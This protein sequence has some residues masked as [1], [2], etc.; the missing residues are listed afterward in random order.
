MITYESIELSEKVIA[1]TRIILQAYAHMDNITKLQVQKNKIK[2]EDSTNTLI[3]VIVPIIIF[4]PIWII[5]S[6]ILCM[7]FSDGV[8]GILG[9]IVSL[10]FCIGIGFLCSGGN[11][12]QAKMQKV[13]EQI[14]QET[15]KIN[16]LIKSNEKI[17]KFIP[18]EYWY[19][20]AMEYLV[21]VVT[22]GRVNTLNEA[23]S[24]YDEQLHRWKMENI[25]MQMLTEKRAQTEYLKSIST[26]NTI[27]AVANIFNAAD[28]HK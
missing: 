10:S 12:V 3:A 19:P 16:R 28:N 13:Q 21:K 18:S 24:M 9:L 17:I 27:S 26:T 1:A 14:E 4:F 6:L 25:N 8:A 15:I 20:M 2:K 11:Q 23:L 7:I 22:T 5:L